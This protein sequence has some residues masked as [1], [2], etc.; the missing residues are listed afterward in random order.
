MNSLMITKGLCRVILLN[1][2]IKSYGMEEPT[3]LPYLDIN[4]KFYTTQFLCTIDLK[5]T[6]KDYVRFA[7]I[8][9]ETHKEF[10][11]KKGFRFFI[12]LYRKRVGNI[13]LLNMLKT[14]LPKTEFI[15][16]LATLKID[17]DSIQ[18]LGELP[19]LLYLSFKGCHTRSNDYNELIKMLVSVGSNVNQKANGSLCTALHYAAISDHD[20]LMAC[21]LA[22]KANPMMREVKGELPITIAVKNNCFKTSQ[23]LLSHNSLNA[24]SLNEIDD[25]Y[26]KAVQLRNEPIQ[27]LLIEKRKIILELNKTKR[28]NK[29]KL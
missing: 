8:N 6:I 9:K 18:A 7:Q 20:G 22:L 15:L 10:I 14:T 4:L 16:F 2:L 21:L 28:K 12:D 3:S 26:Q 24:L 25:L 5:A 1:C 29:K 17:F 23:L 27:H 13:P 19:P 11:S